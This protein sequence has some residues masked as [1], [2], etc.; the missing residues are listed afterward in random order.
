MV[1]F[2]TA[3]RATPDNQIILNRYA[4]HLIEHGQIAEDPSCSY[5]FLIYNN[6]FLSL[7][8]CVCVCV[9][10]LSLSSVLFFFS[11]LAFDLQ[12]VCKETLY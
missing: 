3:I 6:S 2:E 9:F 11:S 4:E 12:W 5:V 1:K 8:V 7:C 10:L